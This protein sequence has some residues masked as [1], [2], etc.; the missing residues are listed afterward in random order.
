MKHHQINILLFLTVGLFGACSGAKYLNEGQKYYDGAEIKFVG[1][2]GVKGKGNL[3]IELEEMLTPEPNVKLM[4]SRPKVWFY[5]IAGEPKKKRGF[6]N[7]MKTKLGTTPIYYSD[8]DITRNIN[9][10]ENKLHNEGYFQA[11]VTCEVK[12][13]KLANT[14]VFKAHVSEPYR[15][16]TVHFPAGNAPLPKSINSIKGE[17]L[18][19][20]GQRYDLDRMKSERARIE[21]ELKDQGYFYFDDQYLLFRADSTIGDKKV[22]LHMTVKHDAPA[23]VQEIY[24]ISDIYV[25][26]N[27]RFEGTE[28]TGNVDTTMVNGIHYI[29]SDNAFKPE[30][31]TR[32]VRIKEGDIYT[33]E[34]ELVSLNR[35]IQLDVFK[36]VNVDFK[37]MEHRQL[38]ADVFLTPFHKK[39]IRLELQAVSKS[40]NNVGPSFMA[41]FRNRNFLRGAEHYELNLTAG[42]EVQVG[43]KTDQPLSSYIL[44]IENVLTV[45]RFVTPLKIENVSS[46][47]VPETKFKLG[48]KTLQRVDLFRLNSIDI[49][50]GFSWHETKTRRH[51]LYPVSIDFIQLGNVSEKFDSVLQ[52]RPIFSRSYEEQFIIGATYSFYYNSQGKEERISNAHNF[53][54]NANFDVS[55]NLLHLL[56]STAATEQNTDD[57]PYQLL[58]SP[59]SQFVKTD[60]DFRHFWRLSSS[61]KLA[62]RLIAGL[63]YAYGNSVVLPYTKQFSVGGSSS[64]RAFRARSVGPGVYEAPEDQNYIDQTADIK[65]EGNVEYRFDVIGAFKGAVFVDAGNVWTLEKDESRSGAEFDFS[66][67]YNQIAVGTGLGLRFDVQFFVLRFDLALPLKTPANDKWRFSDIAVRDRKW[68]RDN[69][70]LNIAIGYPF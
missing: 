53:Y 8:V 42:Y 43:G 36:F 63:G 35:L 22:D 34:A 59:Y 56:Q 44:G 1:S 62:S 29:H 11:Y 51:E 24:H 7:W 17:T 50:Y 60:I 70:L 4:G 21:K 58:G 55:G 39:S 61:T 69:L 25:Y 40:N 23:K 47:F 31:I 32:H 9:L 12:E 14:I 20:I 65:L 13:G 28:V 6:R 16:D 2:K 30:V 27:Y 26:P 54:F 67:F 3:K 10:L 49:N 5:N 64:V 15:Y 18:L 68:R 57:N 46:R 37:D 41:S 45:P 19:K 52:S 33:K 48:F 66:E 38:R